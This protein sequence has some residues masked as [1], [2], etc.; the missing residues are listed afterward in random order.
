MRLIIGET[1]F[2]IAL[3]IAMATHAAAVVCG[4]ATGD[5]SVTVSDG[6]R[7]LREAAG[8]D[9]GACPRSRCDMNL[10]GDIGVSDGVRVLRIAADLDSSTAATCSEAQANEASDRA[11]HLFGPIVKFAPATAASA[12]DVAEPCPGGGSETK[13]DDGFTDTQCRDGDIES[14]GSVTIVSDGGNGFRATLDGFSSTRVS[15][16]ETLVTTG[17]V[18]IVP[19]AGRFL[20]NGTLQ[21]SSTLLGTFT[22][23]YRD[24]LAAIDGTLISGDLETTVDAGSGAFQRLQSLRVQFFPSLT[25]IVTVVYRAAEADQFVT[26][27]DGGL[28]QACSASTACTNERLQ[29]VPCNSECASVNRQ[30]CAPPEFTIVCD[31]GQF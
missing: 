1:L 8:L 22:D 24:V 14:T 16:G 20:L 23:D 4:D 2:S 17:T 5:E 26:A 27:H 10:D 25:A 3:S 9:G 30:R 7:V 6:V 18:T 15:T 11:R 31:D 28:C 29:C 19:Q 12:A 13:R 21:R